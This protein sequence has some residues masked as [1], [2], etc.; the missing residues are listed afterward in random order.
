MSPK[1]CYL[2]CEFTFCY[3]CG[4]TVQRTA[5]SKKMPFIPIKLFPEEI[6]KHQKNHASILRKIRYREN[7]VRK[8]A[9]E[10]N[11]EKLWE[12]ERELYK[13]KSTLRQ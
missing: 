8:Y 5:N 13:I 4:F 9:Q 3:K 12:A 11:K 7:K 2:N 1:K 6:K 10:N